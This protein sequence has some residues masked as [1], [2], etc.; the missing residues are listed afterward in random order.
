MKHDRGLETIS[1]APPAQS[2]AVPN[3][4]YVGDRGASPMV[5]FDVT[6]ITPD[7][8]RQVSVARTHLHRVDR[9]LTTTQQCP[10]VT[11]EYPG[12]LLASVPDLL[13]FH[14]TDSLVVLGLHEPATRFV[15]VVLRFDLPPPSQAR[16]HAACLLPPLLHHD[17]EAVV[18]IVVGGQESTDDLPH[19]EELTRCASILTEAE[20]PVVHQLWT[21]DTA[22]GRRWRCYDESDCT[23]VLPDPAGTASA[24][25][26]TQGGMITYDSRQAII[27]T[28]APEPDDVLARRSAILDHTAEATEA[29]AIQPDDP[30]ITPTENT[31]P[32]HPVPGRS[33]PPGKC[34]D[35]IRAMF[36]SVQAAL[37]AA[38][39]SPPTLS[40]DEVIRLA[41]ALSDHRVRDMCMDFDRLLDVAAAERLWTALA[42]AIPAPQRA[43]PACL[44]A[45][46]AYA[47]G[48]G[49]LAGIAVGQAQK[50]NPEHRLANL[51]RS[52]LA[53]GVE[54]GKIRA[55]GIK[56]AT[57]ARQKLDNYLSTTVQPTQPAT[58]RPTRT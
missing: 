35:H 49:V 41:R 31:R 33:S 48:D 46:F 6:F 42:R 28:L 29:G 22:A 56:A 23:G 43:E 10:H 7:R 44:L 2:A 55:A 19:H 14:P 57:L 20:L 24:A 40:D 26:I 45:F 17:A 5:E 36:G 53:L 34:D 38:V 16:T 21:P 3:Q 15:G 8:H 52:A 51:L 11:L 1:A 39:A 47:R 58:I 27:A 13:G 25:I 37:A 18:L 9:G 54:P 32:G 50:A 4:P 30:T 12:E